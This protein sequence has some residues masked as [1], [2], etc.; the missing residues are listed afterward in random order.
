MTVRV[1]HEITPKANARLLALLQC[2]LFVP[3][4]LKAGESRTF[5][6][7]YLLLKGDAGDGELRS[8]LCLRRAADA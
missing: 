6:S 3:V 7:E 1:G 8:C 5:T 2:P 4:T